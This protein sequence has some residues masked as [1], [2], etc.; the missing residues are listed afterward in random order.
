[1]KTASDNDSIYILAND[2]DADRLAIAERIDK[3]GLVALS[4]PL[5]A[6]SFFFSLAKTGK[7]SQATKLVLCLDGGNSK[8]T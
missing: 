5:S 7:C 2:P 4:Q 3:Y 1:M 6:S 8:S